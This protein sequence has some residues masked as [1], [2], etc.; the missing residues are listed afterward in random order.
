MEQFCKIEVRKPWKLA[1][2]IVKSVSTFSQI[3]SLANFYLIVKFLC[4]F[5]FSGEE[6]EQQ[7]EISAEKEGNEDE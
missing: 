4:Q 6:I 7:E 5:W 1:K 2:K 3:S